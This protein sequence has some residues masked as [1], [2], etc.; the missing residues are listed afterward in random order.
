M[1]EPQIFKANDIRGMVVGE[2]PEWDL[3]GARQLGAAF[4]ELLGLRGGEF[5]LG[6]DMRVLGRELS[7]AFV[8]GANEA[9]ASVVDIGLSATDQLWF[10]SGHLK[11]PGVQFTA[12]HNPAEYNGIKFCLAEAA[13]VASDFTAQ[14]QA[15]AAT[16]KEPAA[17]PGG[18]REVNLLEEYV[19]RLWELAPAR[20]GRELT[21]VADA[22]NGMAGLTS[23]PSLAGR[24]LTV[25]GLF[26]E[27]DGTFPNHPANPLEPANLVAAQQAVQEQQADIGL[28][29]DGDADRCFLIDERGQL[30]DPSA[31][32]AMIA[33]DLLKSEPG[34]SIVV[35]TITSWGVAEAIGELGKLV[36]SQVGHTHVKAKMAQSGAIFGGEHS[37]H[38]YFRDFW[39]A[40]TGMLAA[41]RV[42]ELLRASELPLSQLSS[43]FN[44][45]ARS[46]ELNRKVSDVDQVQRH[47]A[48]AFATRGQPQW[49]DGLTVANR[50]QEWWFNLRA[51][52]TEPLLRLNVE[53]RDEQ[54]MQR[55]RDDVLALLPSSD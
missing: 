49:G 24:G 45:Y 14:L 29:F 34:A 17:T 16:H 20:P 13:P 19:Q 43:R 1:L 11:L 4:V 21:V 18:H 36:V 7:L 26:L 35:N 8:A 44:R 37:G 39:S 6:R 22:G 50:A 51:S 46:G 32:T 27:L 31:I 25:I 42:I 41:L 48:E 38:Y 54:A 15:A 10:A 55:I 9:G 40:D 28:V 52:N 12:S 33:E 5:V 53:A 2:T 47:V 3:A 30:V 23:R